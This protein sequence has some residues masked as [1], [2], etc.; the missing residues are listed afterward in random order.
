M[1]ERRAGRQSLTTTSRA[2]LVIGVAP[3]RSEPVRHHVGR[4]L[5]TGSVRSCSVLLSRPEGL[6]VAPDRPDDPGELVGEGDGGLVVSALADAAEAALEAAEVSRGV[7]PR[8][9]AR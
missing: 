1:M 8:K 6:L 2:R 3:R 5:Q 9:L 7:R 4:S